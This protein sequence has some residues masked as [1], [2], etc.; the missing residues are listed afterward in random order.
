MVEIPEEEFLELQREAALGRL[1]AGVAHEFS[2]PI[3]SL[4]SNRD[5]C[6]RLFDRIE[7]AI[8]DSVNERAV[9]LLGAGREL[10]R[11]DQ[12]AVERISHL[13][14]SLKIASRVADPE[15]QAANLNEILDSSVQLAK[16]QFRD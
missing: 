11:V 1:L 12:M 10:A 16:T 2:A 9:E 3:G 7:Q 14:R 8:A 15:P 13:V 6:L 4:L 5:L